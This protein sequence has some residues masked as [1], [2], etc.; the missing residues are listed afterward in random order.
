[1]EPLIRAIADELRPWKYSKDYVSAEVLTEVRSII[2]RENYDNGFGPR[3]GG[4][5]TRRENKRT[6]QNFLVTL[7]RLDKQLVAAPLAF[8]WNLTLLDYIKTTNVSEGTKTFREL[9]ELRPRVTKFIKQCE[10]VSLNPMGHS[11]RRDYAKQSIALYARQLI[12]KLSKKSQL[13]ARA[14]PHTA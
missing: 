13:P 1:L 11:R 12:Q 7:K 10:Y 8:Y 4:F 14:I 6:A 2:E 5:G 3:Y 9:V